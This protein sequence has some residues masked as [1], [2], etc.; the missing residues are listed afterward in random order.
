L[1]RSR[2]STISASHNGTS[3]S[4][5]PAGVLFPGKARIVQG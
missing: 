5:A 1:A 2:F 4:L 3:L